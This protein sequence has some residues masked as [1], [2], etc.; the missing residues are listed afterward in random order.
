MKRIKIVQFSLTG[1]L[2]SI[3]FMSGCTKKETSP[4]NHVIYNNTTYA[5]S[6]GFFAQGNIYGDSL[7]YFEIAL[8]SDDLTI[9]TDPDHSFEVDSFAGKGE[10]LLA[11]FFSPS[12]E[13]LLDGTYETVPSGQSYNL[14]SPYTWPMGMFF[15]GF[16]NDDYEQ[17]ARFGSGT[18][19]VKNLGNNKY[20]FT[21]NITTKEDKKSFT[22][23]FKGTFKP[24]NGLT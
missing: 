17:K 7:S 1:I 15:M 18:I 2:F 13:K 5:L 11:G 19:T 9:I 14:R 12:S 20:E 6:Q 3:V 8:F 16:T 4:D 24:F 23:Y 10:F 21:F 22:G